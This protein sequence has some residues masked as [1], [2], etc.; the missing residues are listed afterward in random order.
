[1]QMVRMES[2]IAPT[3]EEGEDAKGWYGMRGSLCGLLMGRTDLHAIF[4]QMFIR[5]LC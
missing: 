3:T 4:L 1:M 2:V 5:S